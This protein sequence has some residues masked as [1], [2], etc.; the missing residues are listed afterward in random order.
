MSSRSEPEATDA[1]YCFAKLRKPRIAARRSSRSVADCRRPQRVSMVAV[2]VW[3]GGV[4]SIDVIS[5]CHWGKTEG[6]SRRYIYSLLDLLVKPFHH[7]YLRKAVVI[8]LAMVLL[9]LSQASAMF[10]GPLLKAD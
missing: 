4:L 7:M 10:L 8:K 5:L 6:I 9:V 2:A 1:G 3:S